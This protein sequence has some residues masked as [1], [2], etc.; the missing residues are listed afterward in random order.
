MIRTSIYLPRDLSGR[1]HAYAKKRG[2]RASQVL[3]QAL[4]EKLG[5]PVRRPNGG[6]L[7]EGREP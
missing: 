6:F 1:L 7:T 2:L 4:E 3:R 5:G